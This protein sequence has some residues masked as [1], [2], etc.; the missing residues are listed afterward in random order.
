MLYFR[1]LVRYPKLYRI[2]IYEILSIVDI[3][4]F[5]NCKKVLNIDIDTIYIRYRYFFRYFFR[6]RYFSDIQILFALQ[7]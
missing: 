3:D 2:S 1:A 4:T 6:Y 7:A 5:E